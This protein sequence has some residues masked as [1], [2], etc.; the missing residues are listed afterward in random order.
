[1][2]LH[3]SKLESDINE[4]TSLPSNQI[5]SQ[6]G[7]NK[8]LRPYMIHPSF[9]PPSLPYSPC[10]LCDP[11]IHS[12]IP[13]S[14]HTSSPSSIDPVWCERSIHPALPHP[15]SGAIQLLSLLAQLLDDV[16]ADLVRLRGDALA[17]LDALRG[18]VKILC[19]LEQQSPL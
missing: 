4:S 14:L 9:P 8:C 6:P 10:V 13:L 17:A 15:V 16:R 11:T 3:I 1:M 5:V 2:Y 19:S 18:V 7:T 12:P